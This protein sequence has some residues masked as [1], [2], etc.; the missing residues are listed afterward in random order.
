MTTDDWRNPLDAAALRDASRGARWRRI[1]VVAETGSTN[2]DLIARA[3]A[4]EDIDGAVLI[5]EHQ[6]AGRG[7]NG[8]TWSAVPR[9]QV[10]MSVGVNAEDI[11]NQAWGW[12]PLV[13]G[14]AVLDAVAAV[15]GAEAGLKWPNDVLAR[16]PATGKLA[17]ILAEV[18]APAPVIVIGI[19]LNVSLRADELPDPGATSLAILGGRPTDRRELVVALLDGL[20]RRLDGLRAAGGADP[21]LVSEYTA[22]SLTIGMRV[23]ATL[24]GNREII[25]DAAGVDDQGRL[26]I[27]SGDETVVVAAGDIVHLRP[28]ESA[29]SG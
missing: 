20:A 8:R 18:A 29:G 26:R 23:R 25:G 4:G 28:F 10:T 11:P 14:L 24:P 6:T 21:A 13:A 16:P 5:A 1:D 12:I 22:R 27:D 9:T 17:G 19:G 2:A 3:A 15:A 7:R